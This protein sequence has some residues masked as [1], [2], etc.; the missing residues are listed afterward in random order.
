MRKTMVAMTA[1]ALTVSAMGALLARA[2]E[3]YSLGDC[4]RDGM[5]NASDATNVLQYYS[6]LSTGGELWA[7]DKAKLA[8]MDADG[9]VDSTDASYILGYYSAVS[10]GTEITSEKFMQYK[11]GSFGEFSYYSSIDVRAGNGCVNIKANDVSADEYLQQQ[12]PEKVTSCA[13]EVSIYRCSAN[14]DGTEKRE[15][16]SSEI[17]RDIKKGERV[18]RYYGEEYRQPCD[19]FS[20]VLPQNLETKGY[21]YQVEVRGHYSIGG[22][23]VTAANTSTAMLD[24]LPLIVNN[25]KLT[26]HDAYNL[27]NIQVS[28]PVYKAT[29]YVSAADKKILDEFAAEHFTP[30]MSNYDKI[31]YTWDWLNKNVTYASGNLY[32]DII[33]DSWVSACFVKKKGQCLQYNGALAELLAYMGY[34]VYMLEMWL[35]PDGTNQHFRAEVVIDGQAYSIE[36]GNNGS[37]AGW[38]WLFRPIESSIKDLKK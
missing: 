33:S 37:Y 11:T 8:D 38:L 4:N 19:E 7:D 3:T 10:T 36:V 17:V 12:Y 21:T 18:Y 27:Y 35:S 30:D 28:P 16:A 22:V 29:Y 24:T 9:K 20:A 23:E 32:N 14:A 2:A 6:V 15:L 34:D 26:P 25:A 31:E 13:Y 5:V 1:L